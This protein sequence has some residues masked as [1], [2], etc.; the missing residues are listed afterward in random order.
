MRTDEVAAQ[1]PGSVAKED[2]AATAAAAA[3]EDE[4]P[5]STLA[6]KTEKLAGPDILPVQPEELSPDPGPPVDEPE[7]V[8][9][10]FSR[11]ETMCREDVSVCEAFAFRPHSTLFDST[12][13]TT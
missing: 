10:L 12:I 5:S 3:M 4:S 1:S 2:A 13:A 9:Q 6:V 11:E 7:Q 8:L